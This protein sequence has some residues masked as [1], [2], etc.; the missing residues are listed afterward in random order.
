MFGAGIGS[1]PSDKLGRRWM[2]LTV[3]VIMVGAC[4]LEQ[5]ATNWTHWL[6]ARLLD[7]SDQPP[8]EYASK[9][10]TISRV[11]L[12]AWLNAVSMCT[13]QKWHRHLAVDLS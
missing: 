8:Y 4:I 2:I 10:L 12:S 11:F 7:V 5:L 3:Q 6:G 13:S 1:Y 9:R